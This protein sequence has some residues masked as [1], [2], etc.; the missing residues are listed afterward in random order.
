MVTGDLKRK[1]IY[2]ETDREFITEKEEDKGRYVCNWN[3]K[4]KCIC[5]GSQYQYW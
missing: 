3:T 1:V 5:I 2:D 4:G